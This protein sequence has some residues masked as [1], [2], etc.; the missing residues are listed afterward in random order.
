MMSRK[1]IPFSPPD[2][3]ELEISEVSETLR[4]G[5][6]TTGPKTKQFERDLATFIGAPRV[7]ALGS[8]TAALLMPILVVVCTAMGDKLSAVGGTST[9]LIGVAIAS[10]SAMILP[11]STPPNALAYATN[12]IQQKDMAKMGIIIGAIS[13][14]LGYLVLFAAGS[15]HIV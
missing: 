8:A 1:G 2:I 6:I 3:G 14:I 5:W 13:V 12:L 10:S 4:S 15:L 11:I 7:A 9:V